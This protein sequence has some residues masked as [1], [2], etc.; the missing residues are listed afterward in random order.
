MDPVEALAVRM[1]ATFESHH[2]LI[3]DF[4]RKLRA[5]P[6]DRQGLEL[7]HAAIALQN[8]RNAPETLRA[9]AGIQQ[10]H[11]GPNGAR[12]TAALRGALLASIAA[13]LRSWAG[14][15]GQL[16]KLIALPEDAVPAAVDG[17]LAAP[18]AR[19]DNGHSIYLAAARAAPPD[20]LPRS[21]PH[22]GGPMPQLT[23]RGYVAVALLLAERAAPHVAAKDAKAVRGML[24]LGKQALE[25]PNLALLPKLQEHAALK[26]PGPGLRVVRAV[27]LEAKHLIDSPDKVGGAVR[28]AAKTTMQLCQA[29][30]PELLAAIDD[31]LCRED[32]ASALV[33]HGK[34]TSSPPAHAIWRGGDAKGKANAWLMT[35]EDGRWAVLLKLK[36]RWALVEGAPDDVLATVPAERF[37][38]AVRAAQP[39]R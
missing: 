6:A 17:L 14:V 21:P 19:L 35:L 18:P 28:A 15:Y 32:C 10:L 34:K 25:K 20:A 12:L 7:E 31:A 2:W 39:H 8:P 1:R 36:S 5:M 30:A 11:A 16:T 23:A 26:N 29:D 3:D 37:E 9:W 38:E 24:A 4:V 22:G 13:R 33:R 27:L